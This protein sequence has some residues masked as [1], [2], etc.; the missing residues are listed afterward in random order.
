MSDG[1]ARRPIDEHRFHRVL[2]LDPKVPGLRLRIDRTDEELTH[3]HEEIVLPERVNTVA[4][5]IVE[6]R[7]EIEL[8]EEGVRW[9]ARQLATLVAEMDMQSARRPLAIVEDHSSPWGVRQAIDGG[10]RQDLVDAMNKL[11][12][13]SINALENDSVAEHD[14]YQEAIEHLVEVGRLCER[15]MKAGSDGAA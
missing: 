13:R 11:S 15:A 3:L 1:R 6:S 8:T 4:H 12:A 10:V 14:L 2:P 7:A 9:L 5:R